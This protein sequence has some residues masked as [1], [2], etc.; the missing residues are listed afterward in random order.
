MTRF[1]LNVLGGA[2]ALDMVSQACVDL[3]YI[4]KRPLV[5][6]LVAT[7]MHLK[8]EISVAI[9]V[10]EMLDEGRVKVLVDFRLYL[11][12]NVKII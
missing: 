4:V 12:T 5:G 11:Y 10:Y 2:E 8:N 6:R 7:S 1:A 9:S 3:G